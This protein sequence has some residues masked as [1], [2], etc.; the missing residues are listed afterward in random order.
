MEEAH[1]RAHPRPSP[2]PR[3]QR[4]RAAAKPLDL[5]AHL[6]ADRQRQV[7]RLLGQLLIRLLEARRLQE[8]SHD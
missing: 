8:V 2:P 5:W 7:Q 6:P 4:P 3:C 1:V